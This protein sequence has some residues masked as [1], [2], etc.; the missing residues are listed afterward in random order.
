MTSRTQEGLSKSLHY[1]FKMPWKKFGT[2]KDDQLL[3]RQKNDT[4]TIHSKEDDQ[5]LIIVER[6]LAAAKGE[7]RFRSGRDNVYLGKLLKDYPI[8][9][10]YALFGPKEEKIADISFFKGDTI[11]MKV[12][13]ELGEKRQIHAKTID[14]GKSFDFKDEDGNILFTIDKRPLDFRDSF[15][16]KTYQPMESFIL[17][18][19]TIAIDD[20]FHP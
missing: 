13:I 2:L 19:I 3:V 20:F 17:T 14:A 15:I 4:F 5:P 1:D 9:R 11:G 6:K 16:V 18:A 12:L 8:L 10:S 7:Y